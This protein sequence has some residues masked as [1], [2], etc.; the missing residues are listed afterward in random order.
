MKCSIAALVGLTL[1]AGTGAVLARD[2]GG[3][4]GGSHRGASHVGRP[5]AGVVVSAPGA[6]MR[7]GPV[8]GVRPGPVYGVHPPVVGVRPGPV[9]IGRPPF[10]HRYPGGGAVIVAAPV[11]AYPY[12]PYYPYPPVYAAPVYTEPPTY[13]EQGPEVHYFCPDTRAYYPSVATCASPWMQVLPDG[14]VVP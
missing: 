13:I 1:L 9:V 11:Y 2:G 6:I 8:V 3:H 12:Y 10:F 7:P 14:T 4:S 5:G